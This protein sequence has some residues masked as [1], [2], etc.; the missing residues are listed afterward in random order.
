MKIATPEMLDT[1]ATSAN[2]IV[3][4]SWRIAAMSRYPR[5]WD[6][7]TSRRGTTFGNGLFLGLDALADASDLVGTACGERLT[8]PDPVVSPQRER[9]GLETLTPAPTCVN[10]R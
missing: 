6:L 1:T 8:A 2:T 7:V 5:A 3:R 10:A 4:V 9:A